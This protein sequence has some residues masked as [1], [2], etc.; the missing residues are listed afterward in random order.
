MLFYIILVRFDQRKIVY[1][2]SEAVSWTKTFAGVCIYMFY[3]M[4]ERADAI[5][6]L[7][8]HFIHLSQ[9]H[10]HRNQIKHL[11]QAQIQRLRVYLSFHFKA[12]SPEHAFRSRLRLLLAGIRRWRLVDAFFFDDVSYSVKI[13]TGDGHG[14]FN[15]KKDRENARDQTLFSTYRYNNIPKLHQNRRH[16]GIRYAVCGG[17]LR[18]AVASYT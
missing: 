7:H 12:T 1:V 18:F 9:E 2:Q 10:K 14:R 8:Y 11:T 13:F 5:T 3:H 16:R 6:S 4:A 17:M 15:H